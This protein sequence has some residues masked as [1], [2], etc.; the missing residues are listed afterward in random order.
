MRSRLRTLVL[1]VVAL[2]LV[3]LTGASVLADGGGRDGA[4]GGP[5]RANHDTW[6]P[7]EAT[8]RWALG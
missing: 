6:G 8:H 3:V 5:S 4:R 2:G 1:V 7:I